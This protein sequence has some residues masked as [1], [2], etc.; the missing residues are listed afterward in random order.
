MPTLQSQMLEEG[1][2]AWPDVKVAADAVNAYVDRL[3]PTAEGAENRHPADLYLACA[4]LS[5]NAKALRHFEALCRTALDFALRRANSKA[6]KGEIFS[7]LMSKLLV[8][9]PGFEPRL[10][11][12]F[13]GAELRRWIQI[14]AVHHIL[15]QKRALLRTKSPDEIILTGILSSKTPEWRKLDGASR[16]VFREALWRAIE[17]LRSE[18]RNLFKLRLDGLSTFA[19]GRLFNVHPS[20]VSRWLSRV[21][22]AVEHAVQR[23]LRGLLRLKRHEVDSLVSSILKQVDTSI[24]REVSRACGDDP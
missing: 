9:E 12:Y 20:T 23:E 1:A 11:Q 8:A 24:R 2:R 16:Q 18:D 5:G 21:G 22:V 4:C 17:S 14:V 3:G 15:D 7:I 19:M 6:D 10:G 13:G